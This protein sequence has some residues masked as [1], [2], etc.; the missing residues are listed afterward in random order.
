MERPPVIV[1][2]LHHREIRADQD[3]ELLRAA[4]SL[5]EKI[6]AQPGGNQ[7]I[8]TVIGEQNIVGG[9]DIIIGSDP[10]KT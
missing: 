4:H 5:I 1:Q 9:R 7:S 3:Q 8:Q 2:A 10:R 6:E